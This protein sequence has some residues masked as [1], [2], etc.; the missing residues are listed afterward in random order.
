MITAETSAGVD[1]RSDQLRRLVDINHAFS[2]RT[3]LDQIARFTVEQGAELLGA[4]AGVLMLLDSAEVLSVRAAHG[5][6]EAR[7]ARFQAPL[8]DGVT[9]RLLGLLQVPQESLIAVPLVVGG[10]VTG[11]LAVGVTQPATSL[12]EW[13]LSGLADQA[14][15]ALENARLGGEVRLEMEG[16]LRISE[17]AT[18]AKDRALATLAHDIRSP[19]GAI[20]GYCA[21]LEDGLYG[22][23]TEKQIH[24]V[25]RVRMSGRHLLSL[26]ENVMDMARLTAGVIP[27]HAESV[28]L[29]AIARDSVDILVPASFIKRQSL[30]LESA[31]GICVIGDAARIRQVLVNLIGNAVKFTPAE[32]TITVH[33]GESSE[34]SALAELRVTDTGPGIPEA[35]RAAIFEAYFRSAGTA[36]VPGIGLG[37]AISQALVEQ[38]GGSLRVESEVGTGSSFIL[39]FPL[40]RSTT[41]CPSESNP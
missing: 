10:K 27:L 25:G 41:S 29:H 38:M 23:M 13:L 12:D 19:L 21:V 2:N 39:R 14:A 15:V 1:P 35:D 28:D 37:L 4:S 30:R 31:A 33:L 24:A 16:R 40:A 26:L 18:S 3:S 36:G 11:L 17:G 32:G 5:I 22:V 6:D 9:G 20:E 8:D 7:V 34:G